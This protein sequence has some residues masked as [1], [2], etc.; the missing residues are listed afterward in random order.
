MSLSPT[1]QRVNRNTAEHATDN[2]IDVFVDRTGYR[3]GIGEAMTEDEFVTIFDALNK[4]RDITGIE[5]RVV[6][7]EQESELGIFKIDE[8]EY[9]GMPDGTAGFVNGR[10]DGSNKLYIEHLHDPDYMKHVVFHEVGH[11][12]GLPELWN[13]WAYTSEQTVMGYSHAG[14]HGFTDADQLRLANHWSDNPVQ[15]ADYWLS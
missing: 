7:T 14:F 4:I 11:I 5:Y 10:D 6:G 2:V 12:F 1:Q 3:R 8:A 13:P 9:W 15:L